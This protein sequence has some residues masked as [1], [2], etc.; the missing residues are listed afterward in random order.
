MVAGW[1]GL[2]ALVAGLAALVAGLAALVAGLAPLVAGLAALAAGPAALV[3]GLAALPLFV[4]QELRTRAMLAATA[5]V[6]SGG[7]LIAVF[8]Q[9]CGLRVRRH[10]RL[11]G[12]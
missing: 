6:S 7:L 5:T 4:E 12:R 9:S 11:R 1:S 10:R 2:E 8:L 3:A